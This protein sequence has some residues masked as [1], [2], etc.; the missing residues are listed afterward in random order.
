MKLFLGLSTAAFLLAGCAREDD[1]GYVTGSAPSTEQGSGQSNAN[2]S[3]VTNTASSST[4]LNSIVATNA[5]PDTGVGAA[6]AA[7][8]GVGTATASGSTAV[9]TEAAMNKDQIQPPP[10]PPNPSDTGTTPPNNGSNQ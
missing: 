7:S 5:G 3:E 2:L 9:E 4:R 8:S 1:S 6:T 10:L